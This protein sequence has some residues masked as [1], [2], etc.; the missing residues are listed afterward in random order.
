ME[1]S[2]LNWT[3]LVNTSRQFYS[4]KMP[5]KHDISDQKISKVIKLFAEKSIP[6]IEKY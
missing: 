3:L 5:N 1:N 4:R 2:K 6:K